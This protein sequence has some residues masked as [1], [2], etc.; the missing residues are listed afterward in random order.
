[1][2]SVLTL[3]RENKMTYEKAAEKSPADTET[4]NNGGNVYNA[5]S[6]TTRF[7]S[8][9]VNPTDF[10][11]LDKL[12][13]GEISSPILSQNAEGSQ[14]YKILMLK[15][16]TSP[17]KA[18][19]TDDYQRLQAVALESLQNKIISSWVK[20]KKNNVFIQVAKDY[21]A[22]EALKEWMN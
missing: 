2:D 11:Q 21:Q 16:R 4:K 12:Q 18:N 1:M 7:E 19:L 3:V 20:K 6:G 15:T 9:Q 5:Q 8:D 13:I 10:F 17:H 14:V 22:C